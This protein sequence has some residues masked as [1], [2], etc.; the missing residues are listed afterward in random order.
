MITS[1][2]NKENKFRIV[3]KATSTK[4]IFKV[5]NTTADIEVYISGGN[6]VSKDY[7]VTMGNEVTIDGLNIG[8]TYRYQI[9]PKNNNSG[10]AIISY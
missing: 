5:I 1:R 10:Y 3:D 2:L 6:L 8:T 7:N 4:C 9:I